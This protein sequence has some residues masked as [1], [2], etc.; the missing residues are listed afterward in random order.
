[1]KG[2]QSTLSLFFP[3]ITATT[4]TD[5]EKERQRDKEEEKKVPWEE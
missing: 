2:C 5:D 3:H 1:M 4:P